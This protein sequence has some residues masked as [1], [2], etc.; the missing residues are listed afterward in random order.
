MTGAQYVPTTTY[1]TSVPT[2]TIIGGPVGY[3]DPLMGGYG[4]TVTETT[5]TTT[6]T[7]QGFY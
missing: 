1:V 3:V 4:G 6:T 5:Y 2:A 7:N